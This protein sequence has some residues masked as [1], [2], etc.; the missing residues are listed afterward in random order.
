MRLV[1]VWTLLK[2]VST[3]QI[4][5]RRC[6]RKIEREKKNIEA[7]TIRKLIAALHGQIYIVQKL[8][9]R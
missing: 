7:R 1:S 9:G 3:L 8:M 6:R 2:R 5:L 4:R